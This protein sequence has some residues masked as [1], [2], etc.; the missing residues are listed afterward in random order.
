MVKIILLLALPLQIYANTEQMVKDK[1][2]HHLLL[3]PIDPARPIDAPMVEDY[4]EVKN[5][6]LFIFASKTD[7]QR[8]LIEAEYDLPKSSLQKKF[9]PLSQ[10]PKRPLSGLRVAVDPGHIGGKWA[11][12][13]MRF[14]KFTHRDDLVV[15]EGD[16]SFYVAMQ[17]R[18]QLTTLGA[19]VFLTRPDT[20]M[21]SLEKPF[22]EW[23]LNPAEIA[24]AL[25]R[26]SLES[27]ELKQKPALQVEFNQLKERLKRH[28]P[29][30]VNQ[31]PLLF[32]DIYVRYDLLSRA[33]KINNFNPHISFVIHFNSKHFLVGK[34]EPVTDNFN[35][36]F[37]PGAIT[38][39]ELGD[40]IRRSEF[41][42]LALTDDF[43]KST[44][45]CESLVRN[46]VN[47]TEVLP[48]YTKPE[49]LYEPNLNMLYASTPL[50]SQF[51]AQES[52]GVYSR[53][54]F[55]TRKIKGTFCY[56]ESLHQD[57]EA[58]AE[59]L[60]APERWRLNQIAGAYV[61]AV[62]DTHR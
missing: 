29:I 40:P 54:L 57:N 24:V 13:E 56:G 42:R 21:S 39:K 23:L 11:H 50:D 30:D 1:I 31:Y 5:N 34:N 20:G 18:E 3:T 4:Y 60:V 6:K 16:I 51:Y 46:L 8:G 55:L 53:N 25:E 41:A 32:N 58:E 17:I 10:D 47:F 15:K 44:L 7:K 52:T 9:K 14:M 59:R 2:E 28:E 36:A 27:P 49:E 35:L 38:A 61:Q 37:V 12:L 22:N 26:L 19:T 45:L 33:D 62:L 48:R 43:E